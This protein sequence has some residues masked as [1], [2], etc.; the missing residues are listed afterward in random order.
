MMSMYL[1]HAVRLSLVIM[2][3]DSKIGLRTCDFDMLNKLAYYRK[4]VQVVFSKIDKASSKT[5]NTNLETA[6]RKL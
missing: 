2:L 5:L 4:P 6:A 1:S 3:V